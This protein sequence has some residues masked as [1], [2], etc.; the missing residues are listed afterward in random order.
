M[1]L[2]NQ[3]IDLIADLLIDEYF[4]QKAALLHVEHQLTLNEDFR[5][6]KDIDPKEVGALRLHV[7]NLR[8]AIREFGKDLPNETRNIQPSENDKGEVPKI[9]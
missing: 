4:H 2:S 3:T 7:N 5:I 1:A 8:L 6:Q 9:L